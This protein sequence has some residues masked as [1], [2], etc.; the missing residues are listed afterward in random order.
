MAE[1]ADWNFDQPK[2]RPFAN[3]VAVML[4]TVNT[5]SRKMG[6]QSQIVKI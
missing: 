3:I 6:S 2:L 4:T 5:S 1:N